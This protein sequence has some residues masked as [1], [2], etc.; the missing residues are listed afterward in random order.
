[1]LILKM[2]V[3]S[4]VDS[5]LWTLRTK[6]KQSSRQLLMKNDD[7]PR[8]SSLLTWQQS[9]P[10]WRAFSKAGSPD[11][12]ALHLIEKVLCFCDLKIVE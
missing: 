3:T 12:A 11:T 10:N 4:F 2:N 7:D 5:S 8:I 6:P 9:Q 1:M